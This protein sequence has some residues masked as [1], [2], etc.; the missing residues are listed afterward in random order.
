[1]SYFDRVRKD[2]DHIS[3]LKEWEAAVLERYPGARFEIEDHGAFRR[4][5]AHD[6][7]DPTGADQ[8]GNFAHNAG[9]DYGRGFIQHT[10]NA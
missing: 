3:S 1:M 9:D 10:D 7:D 8:I 5:F 6:G 2:G 4:L